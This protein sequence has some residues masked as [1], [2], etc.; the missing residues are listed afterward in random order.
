IAMSL[1]AVLVFNYLFL[2]PVGTLTIADPQNWVALLAFLVVA[3]V[4][5][6][7][8]ARAQREAREAQRRRRETE[9]LYAFSQL[10]LQAGDVLQ[11]LSAIPLHLA[12]TFGAR[13]AALYVAETGA[14]YRSGEPAALA[15]AALRAG[16]PGGVGELVAAVRLGVRPVGSFGLA[17]A[18]VASEAMEALGSLIAI[19]LERARAVEQVGLTEAARESE[20]LKSVLLDSVAHDFRTP[21]TAI[22]AAITGLLA[23]VPVSEPQRG[24]LLQ[25]IDQESDRL[26]G[27]IEEAAEM[28][29]LEAGELELQPRPL[30]VDEL[31]E[32]AL[33]EC[34]PRLGARP[35]ALE[36]DADLPLVRA[37]IASAKKVLVRLLENADQYSPREQPITI[38]A[39]RRGGVV[40]ISVADRG[41]GIE[42]R[43]RELIFDKFY[44]GREQRHRS[45][46][47][48]MGLAIARAIAA[49]HGGAVALSSAGGPG[50][51]FT[52][53]LPVAEE[54][55][56]A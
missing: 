33:E 18:E 48:G 55:S 5:S 41:P 11:L 51:V 10:L 3:V 7:L 2:P 46:G 35:L 26:N 42:E 28:A 1:E 14:M 8:S 13:A 50:S 56:V 15:E 31:V 19:A 27:L 16:A 52:F 17:G 47:T 9:R 25:I 4:G 21:L 30:A 37:D 29:R 12:S 38:A 22:K 32:A 34:R 45:H 53:T 49:A 43:E 44:R 6:H 39:E 54:R 36:L 40:R 20:R 24:E 23:G